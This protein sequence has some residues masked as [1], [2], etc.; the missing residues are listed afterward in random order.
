MPYQVEVQR[1]AP[2][3][4]RL[5]HVDQLHVVVAQVEIESSD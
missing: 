4:E 2:N 5:T 3:A 1:V